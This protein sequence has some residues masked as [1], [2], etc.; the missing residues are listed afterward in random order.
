MEKKEKKNLSTYMYVCMNQFAVHLKLT[1]YKLTIP[2]FS[3]T[4]KQTNFVYFIY[5]RKKE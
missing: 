4:R 5:K 2:Q 3:K 1:H